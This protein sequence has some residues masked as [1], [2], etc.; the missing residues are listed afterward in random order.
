MLFR[1][2]KLGEEMEHNAYASAQV[3][4]AGGNTA[5]REQADQRIDELTAELTRLSAQCRELCGAY[6]KE[7]RDGY[8]QVSFT[9]PSSSDEALRALPLTA[10]FVAA[11]GG[12][13]LL[14][15]F[16]R[17][18]RDSRAVPE[19]KERRDKTRKGDGV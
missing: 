7:K 9:G 1:S 13:A 19:K 8:I 12:N 15:P 6:V 17:E 4:G 11:W 5:S 10:L 18:Y 16:Y 3:G 14:E 2:T